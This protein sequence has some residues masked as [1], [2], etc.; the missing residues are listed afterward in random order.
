MLSAATLVTGTT[1][2]ISAYRPRVLLQ[3]V[4]VVTCRLL[5]LVRTHGGDITVQENA[6]RDTRGNDNAKRLDA[7]LFHLT[8]KFTA[9]EEELKRV[10]FSST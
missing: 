10:E 7:M 1:L 5:C 9:Y 3:G 4:I 8:R 6:R 2:T